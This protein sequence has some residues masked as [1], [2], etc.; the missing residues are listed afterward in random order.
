MA[1]SLCDNPCGGVGMSEYNFW[2]DEDDVL[3]HKRERELY[4]VTQRFVDV[5]CT[6]L[7][8]PERGDGKYYRLQD[9]THTTEM[10]WCEVDVKDCFQKIGVNVSGK[11]IQSDELEYWYE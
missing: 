7:D 11:P 8:Y 10:Y 4:H 6:Q 2:A 3:L 5:D 1:G 9:D